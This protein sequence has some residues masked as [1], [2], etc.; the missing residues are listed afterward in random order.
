M[1]EGVPDHDVASPRELLLR[2][3]RAHRLAWTAGD[4]LTYERLKAYAA[5]LEA[6][7]SAFSIEK[8][9]TSINHPAAAR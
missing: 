4:R 6:K 3:Q 5:E 8:P 1:P 7:V 9:R 2:A